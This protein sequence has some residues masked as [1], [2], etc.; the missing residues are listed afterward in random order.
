M[1]R[2]ATAAVPEEDILVDVVPHRGVGRRGPR[3]A[4]DM[5]KPHP[6]ETQDRGCGGAIRRSVVMLTAGLVRS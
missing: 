4:V 5:A 6:D 1:G 3:R 2:R